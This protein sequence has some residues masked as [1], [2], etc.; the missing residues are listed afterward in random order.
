VLHHRVIAGIEGEL[1][2]KIIPSRYLLNW[3]VKVQKWKFVCRQ[4]TSRIISELDEISMPKNAIST[5][6]K[7][8]CR[9]AST[10]AGKQ[11][12]GGCCRSERRVA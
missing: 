11:A 4:T 12:N 6:T 3:R 9:N 5:L 10:H 1:L 2:N 8:R 7:L